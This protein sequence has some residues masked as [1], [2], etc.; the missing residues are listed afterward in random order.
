MFSDIYFPTPQATWTASRSRETASI[1][2]GVRDI[3]HGGCA[4]REQ[5]HVRRIQGRGRGGGD[6]RRCA[7]R[8]RLC[9][10]R[11]GERFELSAPPAEHICCCEGGAGKQRLIRGR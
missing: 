10:V 2:L 1:H 5:G 8:T 7:G 4:G 6:A 3:R 11:A 9:G